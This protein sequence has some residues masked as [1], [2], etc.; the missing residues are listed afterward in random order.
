MVQVDADGSGFG[1][2]LPSPART[3]I[4]RNALSEDRDPGRLPFGAGNSM[5][6]TLYRSHGT[7]CRAPRIAPQSRKTAATN[8]PWLTITKPRK[9]EP[10]VTNLSGL[11]HCT[12]H[13]QT[14]LGPVW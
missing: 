9:S 4:L 10:S 2:P 1:R 13:L 12:D 7:L 6:R 3:S 11:R 5:M 8:A 14:A